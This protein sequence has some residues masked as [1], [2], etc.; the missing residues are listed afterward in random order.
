MTDPLDVPVTLAEIARIAGVGRAAVSNW[1]RRHATFPDPVGGTDAGPLF[2]LSGIER[3]LQE[4][5]KI[6]RVGPLDR[7]WPQYEVLGDRTVM[8]AALAEAGVRVLAGTRLGDRPVPEVAALTGDAVRVVEA[9]VE[10]ARSEGGQ[11][12]FAF[13]LSRWLDVHVRQVSTTPDALARLMADIALEV[14]CNGGG[15]AGPVTVLDP[16]CG[17][18]GLLLA[19]ADLLNG[20]EVALWGV[21]RDPTLA[22]LAAVRV[23]FAL[24][25][26]GGDRD[27][28]GATDRR[29]SVARPGAAAEYTRPITAGDSIRDDPYAQVRADIVLCNP[30][31]N[32]RDWGH[33]ELATDSRWS[34]GLP[35]RTE[36]ELAWI[37]HVLARL[38][39]GG[40]A[41]VLV[42][43]AVASRR[44]GRRIRGALLRT[45]ALRTVVALPPGAAQPHSVSLQLWVLCAPDGGGGPAERVLMVDAAATPGAAGGAQGIDW[46][47][48]SGRVLDAVRSHRWYE[49][50]TGREPAEL[51]ER[52]AS[53][54]V[55]ELLD[56]QTDL[57]PARYVPE[58]AEQ[59][60]AGLH[61][62]WGRLDGLLNEARSRSRSL[63]K[64]GLPTAGRGVN[65][66][67]VAELDRA[68][69][70][71]LRAGQTPP[72]EVSQGEAPPGAVPVLNVSDLVLNG[73]PGGWLPEDAVAAGVRAGKLTLAD[74]GDIVVVGVER[75]YRVW[76]QAESPLVLGSQLNALRPDQDILDPWF[77]AGCLRAPANMRQAG[78]HTSSSARID[79]RKLQILQLA[80]PEQKRYGTAFREL[81]ALEEALRSVA[82]AG[83][84]VVRGL[85]DGL[86][87]GR[88][89]PAAS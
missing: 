9:T 24:G 65:T 48:L 84:E 69:A 36:P 57:T 21:D 10:T 63:A 29:G 5:G 67:T 7:L 1:R 27:G 77:L 80:L 33:E 46:T 81:L 59:A 45:G 50:R 17:T 54:S 47:W 18:G 31:F 68:R 44:A 89:G 64:I 62:S 79:V 74:P 87:A 19:A 28:A 72:G 73:A 4:Q 34:Y 86:A 32:E 23:G 20:R 38:A 49:G 76:V 52:C 8:G 16:A 60:Q 61:D 39:P 88:W 35:P 55:M 71:R 41:V 3:W 78:T 85:G 25:D 43:P 82:A 83:E 12:T 15:D 13:L 53:V 37:E 56:E 14:S 26:G 6:E 30:P 11:E 51:P 42:P 66:V 22:A 75:A 70:L 2:S 40:V 58:S